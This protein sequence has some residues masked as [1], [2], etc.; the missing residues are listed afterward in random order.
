MCIRVC[1]R[2]CLY[3]CVRKDPTILPPEAGAFFLGLCPHV[4]CS[5]LV[6]SKCMCLG[7]CVAVRVGLCVRP[8]DANTGPYRRLRA[9]PSSCTPRPAA[10]P[11]P[12]IHQCHWVPRRHRS[13]SAGH[14]RKSAQCGGPAAQ[15]HQ[16]R[17]HWVEG[18]ALLWWEEGGGVLGPVLH[19]A[20][21]RYGVPL[22][23]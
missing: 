20:V 12:N 18:G 17:G 19:F 23:C 22:C 16:C 14:Q 7:S 9:R 11:Q 4:C 2:M 10:L 1:V 13:G 6:V 8:T 21:Q 5:S 15:C 3:A